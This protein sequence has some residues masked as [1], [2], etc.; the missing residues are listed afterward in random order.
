MSKLLIYTDNHFCEKSSILNRFGRNYTVRL[1]NQLTSL[2]WVEQL[3]LEKSC[4]AVIC[5]GDFFDRDFLKDIEITALTEIKWNSLPHYFVVGNHESSVNGLRYN[6]TNILSNE[7]RHVLINPQKVIENNTE[8]CF[9]P[10]VIDSDRK[11]LSEYFGQLDASKKRVIFSHNDIAGIQL[12]PVESKIGFPIDEINSSCNLFLN[13]HLH[14]GIKISSVALNLGNLTGKDFGED[15]TKYDHRVM[16]LDTDTLEYSFIE[17]PHAFNFYKIEIEDESQFD[18]LKK[19]KENS[20]CSIQC[21]ASLS[22]KLRE[23]IK[24]CPNI[25][26]SRVISIFDSSEDS[27]EFDAEDLNVDYLTEYCKLCKTKIENSEILDQELSEVC[28]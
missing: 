11:L 3:A 9:L 17:N 19:L 15:A 28:K 20:V 7:N 4:D 22:I 12:G 6:V 24:S 26:E 16:I 13:G 25:V 14:N 8:I 5:L 18:S 21:K 10:Y 1:E 2:N 23:F 27:I